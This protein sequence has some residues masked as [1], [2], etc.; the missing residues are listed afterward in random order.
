MNNLF[1]AY[2][3]KSQPLTGLLLIFA[4]LTLSYCPLRRAIQDLIKGTPQTEHAK[5][6]NGLQPVSVICLGFAN[7]ANE[8]LILP[9]TKFETRTP[10]GGIGLLVFYFISSFLAT[11]RFTIIQIDFFRNVNSPIPLYL[12]NRMLLI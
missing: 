11:A 2:L 9:E 12:K 8:K 5:T 10:L 4:F 3:K 6:V 7:S 1:K